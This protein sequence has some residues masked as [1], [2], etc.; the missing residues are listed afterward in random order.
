M[1]K[2]TRKIYTKIHIVLQYYTSLIAKNLLVIQSKI[3]YTFIHNHH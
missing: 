1:S 3:F 2:K